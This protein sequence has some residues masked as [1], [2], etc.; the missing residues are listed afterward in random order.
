MAEEE[1]PRKRSKGT[2]RPVQAAKSVH[3]HLVLSWPTTI[4]SLD[5]LEEEIVCRVTAFLDVRSRLNSFGL[6]NRKCHEI[7]LRDAAGWTDDCERLWQDKLPEAVDVVRS[8][9]QRGG[10]SVVAY[11]DSVLDS[12]RKAITLAELC[13]E[14]RSFTFRFKGLAGPQWIE[15]D[16]W[17]NGKAAVSVRFQDNGIVTGR[18]PNMHWRFITRPMDLPRRPVGSYIRI[19]I[20]GRDVPTYQVKRHAP[21]WGFVLESCWGVFANFDLPVQNATTLQDEHLSLTNELQWREAFLYN[22][23]SRI[24]PEGE[25]ATEVFD[26]AWRGNRGEEPPPPAAADE[27]PEV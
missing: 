4:G 6:A 23:G 10:A 16:P 27:E 26:N 18:T 14:G 8:R 7:S 1:P 9:Q 5:R 12:H 2:A 15:N 19:S 21:N 22:I 13:G 17:W 25:E 24:L 11:R 3:N 20:Q